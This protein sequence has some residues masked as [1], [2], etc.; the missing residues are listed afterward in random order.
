MN[1]T[2]LSYAKKSETVTDLKLTNELKSYAKLTDVYKKTYI[3][4]NYY[5]KKKSDEL[6]LTE[7]RGDKIYLRIENAEKTYLTQASAQ[8]LYL[9]KEDYRGIKDAMTLNS[10]FQNNELGFQ[11][12]LNSGSLMD[13]FYIVG[14]KA[15]V[16]KNNQ[17]ILT[18]ST[19][20][21]TMSEIDNKINDVKEW[22]STQYITN[23]VS[24]DNY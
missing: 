13:G 11:S 10:Q 17:Q 24:T 6:F 5:T 18:K 23:W 3:D 9:S 1:N 19:D 4:N 14:D 20:S 2:L 21:Y 16:V 7:I 22:T 15:V 8:S 12:M